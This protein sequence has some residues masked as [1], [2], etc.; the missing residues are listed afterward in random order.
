MLKPNSL[1]HVTA[2][3]G[4]PQQNFDFYRRLLGLRLVKK[5]VNYDDPSTYHLF[6]GDRAGNPGS[7]LSFFCNERFEQGE[8]DTGQ[9][10]AVR[11]AI[12]PTSIDFWTH[13]LS[14]EGID[15]VDPFDRFGKLVIGLQDPDGLHLELVGDPS[16]TSVK[17]ITVDAIPAERAIQA[18][19]GI[20][21][22]EENHQATGQLLQESFGYTEI[23]AKHDRILYRSNTDHTYTI[24]VIDGA[25]ITGEPGKGTIHHIAFR[26]SNDEHQQQIKQELEQIGYHLTEIE[27]RHYFKSFFFHE[28]GGV[29]FEVATDGPG[30][31]V[32][33]EPD[34]L[35][36]NLCL[37]PF[38][39]NKRSLI[40]A[41]LSD[42]KDYQ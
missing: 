14:A 36:S 41:E 10:I 27:D 26:A 22:A 32:D 24:E 39:E 31:T 6:Y 35:G 34:K 21:L 23:A 30:F 15:F 4:N 3:A 38:L 33:E 28:P 17:G 16:V 20:T 25:E 19:H 7:I 5:T 12:A 37:P 9:A 40:E 29:L 2:V 1:H 42:L 11:F 8:P 13:Y 18:L